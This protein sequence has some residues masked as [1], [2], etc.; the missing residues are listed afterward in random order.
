MRS[1][2]GWG[3][4]K[5]GIPPCV[6]NLSAPT[7]HFSGDKQGLASGGEALAMSDLP[8]LSPFHVPPTP[9]SCWAFPTSR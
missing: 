5:D 4:V 7:A 6:W 2:E 1:Q 8:V 9:R 3:G